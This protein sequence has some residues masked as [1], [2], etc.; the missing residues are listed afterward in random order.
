MWFPDVWRLLDS[1]TGEIDQ[2]SEERNEYSTTDFVLMRSTGLFDES[3]KE[4]WEGD[5]VT[6]IAPDREKG[7]ENTTKQMVVEFESS[8]LS[9]ECAYLVSGWKIP[10]RP[11][12]VVGNVYE[13]EVKK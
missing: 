4:I 12:V 5:V 11:C 8:I 1:L 10:N 3:G 2:T 9:D 7:W 13:N 6:W